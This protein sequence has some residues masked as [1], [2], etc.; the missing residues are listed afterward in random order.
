LHFLG[1]K[2]RWGFLTF[3]VSGLDPGM[4]RYAVFVGDR[5]LDVEHLEICPAQ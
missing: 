4:Y 1:R 5:P 2:I 3:T